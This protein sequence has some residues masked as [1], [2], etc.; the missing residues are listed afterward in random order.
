MKKKR[1]SKLDLI[2]KLQKKELGEL[3]K[4]K[5]ELDIINKDEH[6]V[7]SLERK[8]L[9]KLDELK[10]IEEKVRIQ[11]GEHPLRKSVTVRLFLYLSAG[12]RALEYGVIALILG[13]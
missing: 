13:F 2:L 7:S 8:Q 4:E 11:V 10:K 9:R 5:K 6:L 12:S 1:S 3:K